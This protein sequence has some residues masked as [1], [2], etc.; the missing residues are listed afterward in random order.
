MRK[1]TKR[2]RVYS[3]QI[4]SNY[5]VKVGGDLFLQLSYRIDTTF[6]CLFFTSA[7][8]LKLIQGT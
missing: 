5:H 1:K 8:S 2:K 7:S 4:V 3:E 6:L